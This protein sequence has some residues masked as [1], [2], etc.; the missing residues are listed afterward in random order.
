MNC[1][2]RYLKSARH[3]L[4]KKDILLHTKFGGH[5]GQYVATSR[6]HGFLLVEM[7]MFYVY[8]IESGKTGRVYIGQAEDVEK[9][10]WLHNNGHVKSTRKEAP[11]RLIALEECNFREQARWCEKKLKHS[12]GKRIKC[13]EQNYL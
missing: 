1:P 2:W 5:L 13:I 7:Y 8:A 11:W 6:K 12:R 4:L 9:R 3:G 10:I